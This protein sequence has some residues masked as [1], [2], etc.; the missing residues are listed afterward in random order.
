MLFPFPLLCHIAIQA[1]RPSLEAGKVRPSDLSLSDSK[2][3]IYIT[4]ST[5]EITHSQM[6]CCIITNSALIKELNVKPEIFNL[7]ENDISKILE[8]IGVGKDV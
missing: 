8:V 3:G 2:T 7:L 6:F 1:R 5:L 4:F